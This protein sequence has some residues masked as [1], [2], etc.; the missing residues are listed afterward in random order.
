MA[1]L[2]PRRFVGRALWT[3][4]LFSL[5]LAVSSGPQG[6]WFELVTSAS[7]CA[8]GGAYAAENA[9][10]PVARGPAS[11]PDAVA[12]DRAMLEE[13]PESFVH[14]HDGCYLL[15][16]D[17]YVLAGDGSVQTT[18][19]Y[20]ARINNRNGLD[21]MGEWP[22]W[23]DQTFESITLNAARVHKADGRV[24][25]ADDEDIHVRDENTDFA[26]YDLS[27][28]VMVSLAGLEVG[29]V[30]EIKYTRSGVD[31]QFGGQAFG[32]FEFADPTYPVHRS[33]LVVSLPAGKK[34]RYHASASDVEPQVANTDEEMRYTWRAA[35]VAPLPHE[36]A[37]RLEAEQP[38][39][40]FSTYESWDNVGATIDRLHK[41]CE[42]VTPELSALV[43]EITRD[44]PTPMDKTRELA[45]WVR[46]NVRYLSIRHGA[47]GYRPHPPQTV[48]DKRYGNCNDVSQLLHVMLAEAGIAS[49]LVFLNTDD[50][51]QLCSE[52]PSPLA[53][54][55]ILLAE[56]DGRQLWMDPTATWTPWDQLRSDLHGC[57]AYVVD[58]Q[59]CRLVTTPSKTAAE[60]H[61]ENR[62]AVGVGIGGSAHWRVDTQYFGAAAELWRSYLYS[63]LPENR[64]YDQFRDYLSYYAHARMVDDASPIEGLSEA[65]GPLRV[66]LEFDVPDLVETDELDA[67]Q[68]D[69]HAPDFQSYLSIDVGDD[70]KSPVG[71]DP[72]ELDSRLRL[73]LPEV[74]YANALT[75]SSEVK[76]RWG[77]AR[78][79]VEVL[80]DELHEFEVRWRLTLENSPVQPNDVPEF[81][82]FLNDALQLGAVSASLAFDVPFDPEV[83]AELI[84][85]AGDCLGDEA[86]IAT[87]AEALA[88]DGDIEEAGKIVE[89][90]IGSGNDAPRLWQLKAELAPDDEGRL[91]C[92]QKMVEKWPDRHDFQ[93][94]LARALRL[95]GKSDDAQKLLLELAAGATPEMQARAD[96]ELARHALDGK[97]AADA[98]RQLDVASAV[99]P[100]AEG[101]EELCVLKGEAL[102]L[103][104]RPDEALEE[105]L[106]AA[107][108]YP[109]SRAALAGAVRASIDGDDR[110]G[111]LKIARRLASVVEDDPEGLELAAGLF[112]RL[113]RFESAADLAA[114]ALELEPD[115][116]QA[117]GTLI[118]AHH[119]RKQFADAVQVVR[120]DIDSPSVYSALVDCCLELGDF[121]SGETIAAEARALVKRRGEG[122]DDVDRRDLAE[123]RRQIERYEKAAASN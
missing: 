6:A 34:L 23:Y 84:E 115:R 72:V 8:A 122:T 69:I 96:C 27:K 56:L 24:I 41:Q 11:D 104:I 55:A 105:F 117:A 98:V 116:P 60:N 43:A 67:R 109:L 13:L 18:H 70:R 47:F 53:N 38:G 71:F 73:V 37:T 102:L 51:S 40:D 9:E 88:A 107:Y 95:N 99:Y 90:A 16:R 83:K 110:A 30:V 86:A 81:Q 119:R 46:D 15:V 33:E 94:E 45:R 82:E 4:G 106:Y 62:V 101:W 74:F 44:C 121:E 22:L 79:D 2:S 36:E 14:D 50:E 112:L 63:V 111:A 3:V 25:D 120:P 1:S 91:A 80:D 66:T 87:I 39:I 28:Y 77:T 92:Y 5:G 31:P 7:P 68:I 93:L 108:V 21:A 57:R 29:D 64:R 89:S 118:V 123:L 42:T 65:D 59:G 78:V 17:A 32:R 75:E 97:Q 48:L 103:L 85:Q 100:S 35:D 61:I 54:H 12:F 19:H 58:A 49:G 113:D 76:S 52:V 26:D 114:E 20:L 10:A